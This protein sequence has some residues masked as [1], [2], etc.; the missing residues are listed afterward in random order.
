[1]WRHLLQGTIQPT[2]YRLCQCK[3]GSEACELFQRERGQRECRRRACVELEAKTESRL[4]DES[5]DPVSP[6]S[7]CRMRCPHTHTHTFSGGGEGGGGEA[8]VA[9]YSC[10][11]AVAFLESATAVGVR[12][13][14]TWKPHELGWGLGDSIGRAGGQE[15][16]EN[17]GI[18]CQSSC[19]H[20][21]KP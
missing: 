5:K 6:T 1:M 9:R 8:V 19:E 2:H 18:M 12:S 16:E 4:P 20:L 21:G 11:T 14:D 3:D 13:L 10:C 7:Q 17:K 15:L